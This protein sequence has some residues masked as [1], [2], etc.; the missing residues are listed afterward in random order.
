MIWMVLY[1]VNDKEAEFIKY[2]KCVDKYKKLLEELTSIKQGEDLSV[3]E[4]VAS[5]NDLIKE[6]K[7]I[8]YLG[9]YEE[10]ARAIAVDDLSS[11]ISEV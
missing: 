8:K 11:F 3:S 4:F 6:F 7:S 9:I 1:M 10:Q 2:E 5:C